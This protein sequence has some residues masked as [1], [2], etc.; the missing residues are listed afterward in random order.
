MRS[1]ALEG[2]LQ[3][4]AR[5]LEPSFEAASQHLRMREMDGRMRI[6]KTEAMMMRV[7]AASP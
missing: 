5:F 2:G 1:G 6:A 4:A 3:P 7:H